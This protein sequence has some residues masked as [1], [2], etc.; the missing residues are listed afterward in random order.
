M[1]LSLCT[2]WLSSLNNIGTL[3]VSPPTHRPL[4][5]H[6]LPTHHPLPAHFPHTHHPL[7]APFPHT[8]H[9]THRPLSTHSPQGMARLCCDPRRNVRHTAIGY[10]Q[11]ALLAHDLQRLAPSEWEAC[12]L[13]VCPML[14][15]VWGWSVSHVT[16]M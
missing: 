2:V 6:S 16:V 12:F 1:S 14:P 3:S 15:S 8:L 13:E 9:P 4:Y 10:L 11:R 7:P 5:T